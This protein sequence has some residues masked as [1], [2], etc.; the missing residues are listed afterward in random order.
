VVPSVTEPSHAVFLSYTSQDVEAAQRIC[1]ALR[2]AG[3]E[4]WFDQS[5]LRGGD[6]WDRQIR[7][8]IHDCALFIP[9][10]SAH[11]D[12][13]HEGYFR[14]EWRL[15]VERAG[16]M[17]ED[18]PFL[19]PVVIDSTKDATA[20]VPERFREVQWSHAPNGNASA[21]FVERVRSLLAPE[22]S[23]ASTATERS[24]S[25][26]SPAAP[27][28][29][30]P[31][32]ASRLRPALLA[33]AV[34]AIASGAY[35]AVDRFVL[36]K[37]SASASVPVKDKSIAVLP[38]AD[39]SEG[40][41][42]EYFA[43]GVA[44]EILNV[45]AKIPDLRVIGRTSSFSFKGKQA[46]LPSIGRAL[47]VAYLVEGSVRRSGDQV[48]VTAQL[49]DGRDGSHRWSDTFEGAAMDMLK[50]QDEIA[51]R[52]AH[53]LDLEVSNTLPPHATINSSEA[54]DYY[55]RGIR[56]LDQNSTDSNDTA[57]EYFQKALALAP[58]FAPAAVEIAE[59]D[60]YK[61]LDGTQ[62]NLDGG[63]AGA[64]CE[65]ALASV[66]AA[67]KLD[68]Q[69]ADAYAVRAQVLIGSRWDWPG[70]AAAISQ[71]TRLGGGS[72]TDYAA[73][74]LAYAIGDM[75]RARQILQRI[76]AN[77]PFEPD[78]KIDMGFFVELRSGHFAEAES[79]VRRGLQ[80]SP[81]YASGQYLLGVT[82]LMQDKLDDALATVKQEK[83]DE[84]QL[85][86]LA[87]V[88][89]ALKRGADSDAALEA[90]RKSGSYFPSDFAR[91]YAFRGEADR[92]LS[93]LEKAYQTHDP[94][95]WYIKGDPLFAKLEGNPRYKAFLRKMNLPE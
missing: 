5:E 3:I 21:A 87:M 33:F 37:R 73:A 52:V 72:R 56:E 64:P 44:E 45:L 27:A 70:A 6:V 81:R 43:D 67:L 30:I 58:Q 14:R 42:Q 20:R 39:L 23:N 65:K 46:D 47:G 71:A 28:A 60:S 15:A 76:N 92:A 53:S 51:V 36:S 34:L 49:I 82:L 83:I 61:C 35:L 32:R 19:V 80:I 31:P 11:S 90:M 13:R 7:K 85:G 22:P 78:A 1:E 88:Y 24:T 69:S 77:N 57:R 68:P 38:F 29:R 10:I 2:A 74:R 62:P 86:G 54:Y 41:D 17:A 26:T 50:L 91:A 40:H 89:T 8:Q 84:G 93:E 9:V 75:A 55:L 63:Q 16:D 4:V 48:R 25:T 66:D 18:V 95:L 94:Y 59:T 79:W 12:A